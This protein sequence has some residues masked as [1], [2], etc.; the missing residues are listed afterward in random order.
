MLL[1][2]FAVVSWVSRRSSAVALAGAIRSWG[3]ARS[4]HPLSCLVLSWSVTLSCALAPLGMRHAAL[5]LVRLR[6]LSRTKRPPPSST[7][8][9]R[10]GCRGGATLC[11]C[12]LMPLGI[13]DPVVPDC[14]APVRSVYCEATRVSRTACTAYIVDVDVDVMWG[15]PPC[16]CALYPSWCCA[17]WVGDVWLGSCV[18]NRANPFDEKASTDFPTRDLGRSFGAAEWLER[19]QDKAVD[20]LL[21]SY[22]IGETASIIDH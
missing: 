13:I 20:P 12:C 16:G 5:S 22:H 9:A 6:D 11:C 8:Q 3:A 18:G 19:I 21:A 15:L 7:H 4:R 17:V 14:A 2:C 1:G 10:T